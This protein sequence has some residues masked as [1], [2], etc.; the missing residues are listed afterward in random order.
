MRG[1]RGGGWKGPKFCHL[2]NAFWGIDFKLVVK[3][4]KTDSNQ[5][6]EGR[7]FQGKGVKGL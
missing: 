4:Q 6:G 5:R 3:K 2:K 7:A 1:G